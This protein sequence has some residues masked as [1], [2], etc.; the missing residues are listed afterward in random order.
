[1]KNAAVSKA[2]RALIASAL[3]ASMA[4]PL[5]A[6]GASGNGSSNQSVQQESS[7]SQS[8]EQ[9][10]ATVNSPVSQHPKYDS[11]VT[12]LTP[13]DLA[14]AGFAFGDSCDVTFSNGYTLS[15]VPYYNGYYVRTGDPVVVAYPN[16]DYI[17]VALCNAPLFSTY[18][19]DD[20][21]TVTITLREQGKYLSTFEALSQSYSMD[22]S[23]YGSDEQFANF[24]ALSGGNLKANFLYRGASPVDNS[25]NRASIASSLLEKNGIKTVVDLADTDEEIQKDFEADGFD[26][27]YFKRLYKQG[28]VVALDMSSDYESSDYKASVARGMRHLLENGGP[29]YIHCM[30]GKDRTG[31]VCLVIEAL[32]GASY[33]EMRADYMTTY[34]NYYG[35]TQEQT[36]DRYNAVVDLYFADFTSY[37]TGTEDEE[38]RKQADYAAC[39]KSYLQDCGLT[40]TEIAQLEKLIEN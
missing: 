39:A 30:E 37:L 24:R 21:C 8:S 32:A 40:A 33:D 23:E 9:A 1:M 16:D 26:S 5:A 15:D 6:C 3:A 28:K 10:Q 27:S 19:L 35:I 22:R 38:A 25:R 36:P 17:I 13:D 14:Q 31:F 7:A 4:L 12:Q 29:A 2:V 11:V 20:T 34:E 18:H